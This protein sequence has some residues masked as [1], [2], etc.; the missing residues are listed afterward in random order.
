MIGFAHIEKSTTLHQA[1]DY[2]GQLRDLIMSIAGWFYS[3][4]WN[5]FGL[6]KA[7][8]SYPLYL[9]VSS[10]TVTKSSLIPCNAYHG[11]LRHLSDRVSS[12]FSH[13]FCWLLRL[14]YAVSYD[15]EL[16]YY[17]LRPLL[18]RQV[19]M[20]LITV[21]LFDVQGMPFF[22]SIFTFVDC[23]VVVTAA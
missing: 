7:A 21:V 15:T 23:C 14:P 8:T 18:F 10:I 4:I 2:Q 13:C 3:S 9:L 11:R 19:V 17:L 6:W 12:F 16:H 22:S 5:L 20:S 1:C